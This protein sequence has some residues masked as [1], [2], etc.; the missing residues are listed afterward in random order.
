[1]PETGASVDLPAGVP[2]LRLVGEAEARQSPEQ[3]MR[4]FRFGPY[5]D[6]VTLASAREAA[7]DIAAS[8]EVL[9]V[10]GP[11][12]SAWRVAAPPPPD[13]DAAALAT[14]IEAAGFNDF[15]LIAEGP[16]AGTVALGRFSTPEAA[17]R[18]QAALVQAGFQAQVHPVGGNSE[19]V[20]LALPADRQP[21][22]VRAALA[23]LQAQPVDC[24]G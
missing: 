2:G 14:R 15:M 10:P 18:R 16:E 6:P 21:A 12:P 7:A 13:G 8:V 20:R 17:A 4:C 5:S 24:G 3:A 11:A 1:A 23:A 9:T 19:W 22:D